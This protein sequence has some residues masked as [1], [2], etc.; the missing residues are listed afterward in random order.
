MTTGTMRTRR[1][2]HRR[3]AR[4]ALLIVATVGAWTGAATTISAARADYPPAPCSALSGSTTIPAQ[5]GVVTVHGTGFVPD[6]AVALGLRSTGQVLAT[7]TA[8]AQGAFTTTVQLPDQLTGRQVIVATSGASPGCA[9][10]SLAVTILGLG[11]SASSTA[12]NPSGGPPASTGVDVL[13]FAL[14]GS[15]L[16]GLGLMLNRRWQRRTSADSARQRR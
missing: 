1:W 12:R 15:V 13:G 4:T 5:G 14:L 16:I 7:V 3:L 9:Q 11:F 8:D 10:P 2:R 6:A